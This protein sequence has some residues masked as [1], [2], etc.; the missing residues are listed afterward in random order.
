VQHCIV[1]GHIFPITGNKMIFKTLNSTYEVD[2]IN[3]RM[4]QVESNIVMPAHRCEWRSFTNALNVEV[5]KQAVFYWENNR[6]TITSL[7]KEI[8]AGQWN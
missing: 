2:W 3:K 7:V 8:V 6:R 4:R 1:A 5:G